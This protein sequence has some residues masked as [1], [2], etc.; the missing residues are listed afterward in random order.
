MGLQGVT[1]DY[2]GLQGFLRSYRGLQKVFFRSKSSSDTFS[3]S[4]LHKNKS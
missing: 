1:R 2:R 3:W 4:I